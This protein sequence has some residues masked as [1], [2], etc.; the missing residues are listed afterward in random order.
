[1]RY[2]SS[3]FVTLLP[4]RTSRVIKEN[5]LIYKGVS[6]VSQGCDTFAGEALYYSGKLEEA[7]SK[8]EEILKL[9]PNDPNA[10]LWKGKTELMLGRYDKAINTLKQLSSAEGRFY[11]SLALYL[12]SFLL[13]DPEREQTLKMALYYAVTASNDLMRNDKY[14]SSDVKLSDVARLLSVLI[15]VEQGRTEEARGLVTDLKSGLRNLG[16]IYLDLKRKS[17]TWIDYDVSSTKSE[18]QRSYLSDKPLYELLEGLADLAVIRKLLEDPQG[19]GKAISKLVNVTSSALKPIVLLYTAEVHERMNNDVAACMTYS[20]VLK[21]V[22][23]PLVK[24]RLS[25]CSPPS[26][27]TS[28]P[29]LSR[30]LAKVVPLNID[31]KTFIGSRLGLYHVMGLIGC[32]GFGYVYLGEMGSN[33]YA[34]KV[35]KLEKGNP[36]AYFRDLF[37]EANNL[38]E[39]S[40]HKY[41]VKIYAVHVDLNVITRVLNGDLSLYYA[42]PPRIIMEYMEGGSLDKYVTN[43]FYSSNWEKAV[44]KAVRQIAEALAYI[45]GRGYVHL[46]VKPQNIFLTKMPKDPSDLLNVDFK[47]GDLGSA[48]RVN[49][50]IPQTTIEYYPPEVFTSPAKPSMDV[51]ALGITLYKLLTMKERPD[52]Q[53]IEKA[54]D[55]YVNKDMDC[56]RQKVDEARRLLT[57]WDPEVPEPYKTLIKRMTDLDPMNR[58]TADKIK[59]ELNKLPP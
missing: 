21:F 6:T 54:S 55:C 45:H 53:A 27:L 18:L 41:I 56:V 36:M 28:V 3:N 59:E 34:I 24:D 31:P 1:M 38:V 2:A 50:P 48:V 9:C 8:F 11:L 19:H 12:Y 57:S 16:E 22:D 13:K 37:H 47:L 58:P 32:G 39:L 29:V 42:D 23:S 44:V 26:P 10:L 35:L 4:L 5:G 40:N 51:F 20:D 7:Y 30:P 52:L 49:S 17:Y 14:L 25:R 43:F 33:K 15:L 46:D